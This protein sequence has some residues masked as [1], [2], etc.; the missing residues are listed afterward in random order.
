MQTAV[1]KRRREFAVGRTCARHALKKLGWPQSPILIGRAHEPLWPPGIVGSITHCAGFTAASV[2]RQAELL[3]IGIDAE[4]NAALP[5]GVEERVI[6]Q[7][8]RHRCTAL[9]P[10]WSTLVFSAKESVYKAW[11]PVTK[12]WLGYLEVDLAF[13]PTAGEFTVR[14]LSPQVHPTGDP[15]PRFIGRFAVTQEHVFTT[16]IV[17]AGADDPGFRL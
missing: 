10:N 16:A 7:N 15:H 17:R 12:R 9:L 4:L 6:T 8:E 14:I 1:E 13:D 11:Y 3:S 2:A 5:D